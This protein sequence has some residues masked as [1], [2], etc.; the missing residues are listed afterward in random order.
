MVRCGGGGSRRI[1]TEYC[2]CGEGTEE[3]AEL[4]LVARLLA[5]E[6]RDPGCE[7]ARRRHFAGATECDNHLLRSDPRLRIAVREVPRRRVG[8][9][10]TH[11]EQRL[12]RRLGHKDIPV[13][14]RLR[15]RLGLAKGDGVAL[16]EVVERG[17]E[18]LCVVLLELFGDPRRE[19]LDRPKPD[20][21]IPSGETHAGVGVNEA[22]ADGASGLADLLRAHGDREVPPRGP[23][24]GSEPML[25]GV[26]V[27]NAPA[28]LDLRQ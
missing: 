8:T 6:A 28:L 20:G 3:I 15:G 18:H 2:R 19:V 9:G 5:D 16:R 14:E 27:L 26:Q 25:Y 11:L 1:G 13:H 10:K 17:D 12:L 7:G 4:G 24:K 23:M 21:G 22:G